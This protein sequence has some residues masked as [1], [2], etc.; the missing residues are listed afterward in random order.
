[1]HT[2]LLSANPQEIF[3]AYEGGWNRLTEKF[4]QKTEWPEADIIAPLVN[5]GWYNH[6]LLLPLIA[7]L[8]D[9]SFYP[10]E[11]FLLFYREL[12]Y[13][14]VYSRLQPDIDDRF[15]SYENYCSIFNYILNSEGP[16][17]LDLPVQ[18]LWDIIDE[19]I[20]Q[21]AAFTTWKGRMARK[22]E[23]EIQLIA[24]NPQVSRHTSPLFFII[25]SKLREILAPFQRFG[26]VTVF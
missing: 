26:L 2:T 12:Y 7:M 21:F 9:P 10:D 15:H 11:V 25:I 24:E 16:V 3:A 22:T 18:W 20:Y 17:P 23:E 14:H 6:R 1:L 19:F 4:Y 5:N 13:R 8:I